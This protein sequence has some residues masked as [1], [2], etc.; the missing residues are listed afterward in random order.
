MNEFKSQSQAGQDIFAW[1]CSGKKRDGTFLDIGSGPAVNYNN[2][3]A[4]EQV[5]WTGNLIDI[6]ESARES[7]V[8]F[9]KAKFHMENAA[10]ISA[11]S[12]II[13]ETRWIDYLSLDVDESSHQALLN[14]P[15]YVRFGIITIEHDHYRFGDAPR[16][17]MR[18]FL[19]R[20][21]YILVA[22]DVKDQGLEFEDWW[23]D[24]RY[25]E[26]A[27]PFRSQSADW[28]DVVAKA[29]PCL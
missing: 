12:H 23:V 7:S 24:T 6:T 21:G 2:S 29:L 11:W 17:S 8:Q 10:R 16:S 20:A 25:V 26:N 14:L 28:K 15:G 4:L 9:R 3:Y 1:I 27:E 13:G 5:G 19:D 18:T 22:S